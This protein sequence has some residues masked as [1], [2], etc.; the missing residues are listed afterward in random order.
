MNKDPNTDID[1]LTILTYAAG[2]WFCLVGFIATLIVLLNWI[3]G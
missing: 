1:W 2:V 3:A